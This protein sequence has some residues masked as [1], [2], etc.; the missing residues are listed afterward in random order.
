MDVS[1]PPNMDKLV[2]T[3]RI[4]TSWK[5]N[6]LRITGKVS[7]IQRAAEELGGGSQRVST[8]FFLPF[9]FSMGGLGSGY[10]HIFWQGMLVQRHRAELQHWGKLSSLT[11]CSAHTGKPTR[12]FACL[13][14]VL[15]S[16]C[17]SRLLPLMCSSL[18]WFLHSS[19]FLIT[20]WNPIPLL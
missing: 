1:L 14:T 8:S 9:R 18:S 4:K 17:P 12:W 16:Y 5:E 3:S 19:S 7:Y 13:M 10:S 6:E 15:K 2:H 20:Y 11:Y